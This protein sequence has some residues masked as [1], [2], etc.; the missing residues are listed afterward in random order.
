MDPHDIQ[1]FN[2]LVQKIDLVE[3]KVDF[4]FRHLGLT[5]QD[6]RPPPSEYEKHVIAGDRMSAI[7]VYQQQHGVGLA[8][9]QRA[10]EELAAKLGM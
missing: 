2:A 7:K 4:L 5:F 10:I 1:R 3:R 6:N 9:A 8:D